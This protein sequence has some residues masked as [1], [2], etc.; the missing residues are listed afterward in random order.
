MPNIEAPALRGFIAQRP[1]SEGDEGLGMAMCL[2]FSF[3]D[4]SHS[5]YPECC[6]S[7]RK[8]NNKEKS[9]RP[10]VASNCLIIIYIPVASVNPQAPGSSLG[11]GASIDKALQQ[12]RAFLCLTLCSQIVTN[13][14]RIQSSRRIRYRLNDGSWQ[15]NRSGALRY[16][17]TKSQEERN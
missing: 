7:G 11:R 14:N 13:H 2:L 12:C 17:S 15:R 4:S 16:N 8:R 10:N 1:A 5:K 9:D 6:T 3:A